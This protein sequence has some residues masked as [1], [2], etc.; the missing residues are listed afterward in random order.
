MD[1]LLRWSIENSTP[2]SPDAPPPARK[3]LDPGIIDYLL[4]KPD[5]VLMKEALEVALDEKRGEDTRVQAL[6]DFEMLV[7]H[8]DNANGTHR[9]C[10]IFIAEPRNPHICSQTSSS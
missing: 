6:D 3:D 2:R 5:A 4:G 9:C 1:S 7:E 8:I 10:I